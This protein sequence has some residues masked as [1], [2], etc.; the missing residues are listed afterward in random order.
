MVAT[1]RLNPMTNKQQP[2]ERIWLGI[3]K[4]IGM[5]FYTIERCG[6]D[7]VEYARVHQTDD[8]RVEEIRE[9]WS[10]NAPFPSLRETARTDIKTLLGL[11]SC[12]ERSVTQPQCHVTCTSFPMSGCK[13]PH[14]CVLDEGHLFDPVYGAI[15]R[16]VSHLAPVQPRS[17][18]TT[19]RRCGELAEG[20]PPQLCGIC[21]AAGRVYCPPEHWP[22]PAAAPVVDWNEDRCM[23]CGGK[24][25][26]EPDC[27]HGR[28]STVI[29]SDAAMEAARE[30]FA[31]AR[32]LLETNRERTG[33]TFADAGQ[34]S[35]DF[36]E[37]KLAAIILRYFLPTEATLPLG[38]ALNNKLDGMSDT[39]ITQRVADMRAR[40]DK[41]AQAGQAYRLKWHE[42]KLII[43]TI[44][45]LQ[46]RL[47][48]ANDFNNDVVEREAA[49]CP[50][51][52]GFDEYIRSL[53][54]KL[55]TAREKAIGECAAAV[56]AMA[57]DYVLN[58]DGSF[59]LLV[60][61]IER[62]EA[63]VQKGGGR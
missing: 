60:S 22:A 39:Q 34:A 20:E 33:D 53:E 3:G 24:T 5:R 9:R 37:Q 21:I 54:T 35:F 13:E 1:G 32:T 18:G 27:S 62:L 36:A 11:L 12:R 57:E 16:F 14:R 38:E 15:H 48:A 42:V 52:V 8:A 44:Q 6:P 55:A 26:H 46:E 63:L 56:R 51:D 47:T 2:P 28:P 19:E 30:W 17:T 31:E 23:F 45:T 10:G 61:V 50:E 29:P 4:W 49:V 59:H 25:A 58:S 43:A 40:L 7:D 41:C